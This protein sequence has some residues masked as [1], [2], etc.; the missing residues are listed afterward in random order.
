MH[1]KHANR[2]VCGYITYIHNNKQNHKVLL[3]SFNKTIEV[4]IVNC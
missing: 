1:V 4:N 3:G 2:D